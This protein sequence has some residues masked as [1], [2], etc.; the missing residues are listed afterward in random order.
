MRK[1]LRFSRSKPGDEP[2][3]FFGIKCVNNVESGKTFRVKLLTPGDEK[4]ISVAENEHIWDAA[5]RQGIELPALC[6]QGWCLT[7]AGRLVG[8]GEFDQSDSRE[9]FPQDREDSFVLLC[10]ARA[11]SNLV[12][13]THQATE[14]RR[15]R[16]RKGL[17]AP[18]S[19]GLRPE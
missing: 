15:V 5:W 7:C 6:H 16:L 12:I 4:T 1:H 9:F 2:G 13:R 11:C 10:T 14:L 3:T 19:E 8:Q 18:Y 17:P